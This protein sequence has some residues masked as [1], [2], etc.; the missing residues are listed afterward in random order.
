MIPLLV[1]CVVLLALNLFALIAVLW[2]IGV[3][4]NQ[5]AKKRGLLDASDLLHRRKSWYA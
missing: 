2:V 4:V 1:T 5:V 3:R